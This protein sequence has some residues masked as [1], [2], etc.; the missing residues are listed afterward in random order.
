MG[1]EPL[2]LRPEDPTARRGAMIFAAL[3]AIGVIGLV[4]EI[5]TDNVIGA[6]AAAIIAAAGVLLALIVTV[7][8]S[9]L[10]VALDDD[11]LHIAGKH[12]A[13]ADIT[14]LRR[15][16]VRE[17][18]LDVVGRDDAVLYAMPAWFDTGQEQQLA[19]ALGVVI[20]EP[21]P[22]EDDSPEEGEPVP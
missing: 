8:R 6:V 9:T 11:T 7:G 19:A 3:A 2:V 17:G 21:P 13:R 15:R 18:G 14:G 16:P 5:V 1:G 22:P 12:V 4:I 20:V 10:R